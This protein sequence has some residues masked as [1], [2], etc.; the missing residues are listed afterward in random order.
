MRR[1]RQFVEATDVAGAAGI[2]MIALRDWIRRGIISPAVAVPGHSRPK[3]PYRDVIR[4]MLA[5][6]LRQEGWELDAIAEHVKHAPG[7]TVD[8]S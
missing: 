5:M 4:A 7:L 2:N 8:P 3:H 6:E 1:Y